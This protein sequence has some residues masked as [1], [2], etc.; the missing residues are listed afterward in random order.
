MQWLKS[1]YGDVEI[2][3]LSLRK[4]IL[5]DEFNGISDYFIELE[6][7]NDSIFKRF[8][9]KLKKTTTKAEYKKKLLSK[10]KKENYDY[11]YANSIMSLDWG[12]LIKN[13][14][15]N[16]KL[17]LH[18]HELQ[19]SVNYY[20][21]NFINDKDK[22]DKFICVSNL[23]QKNI[24]INYKVPIHKT[25][26]VYAFS[27]LKKEKLSSYDSV[28]KT[29]FVI[30]ASGTVNFRK[31]YDLFLCVAKALVSEIGDNIEFC[32]IGKF[33]NN[34]IKQEVF[35]DIKKAG[36]SKHVFFKGEFENPKDEF[37]KFDIF[38][39]LSREDP[40]P[41]VCIEVAN[42]GKP[43]ICFKGA[44]G[45]EEVLKYGG[46]K[47]VPY[48]DINAVAKE[49]KSYI[50]NPKEIFNDGKLAHQNFKDFTID[51]QSALIYKVLK[52]VK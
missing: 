33:S 36:L 11:I 42:L 20:A 30:G 7:K 16:S 49:V 32:W 37:K 13:K 22:V 27:N 15:P 47:I 17:I 26:V 23:V 2:H 24:I 41:L 38:L 25:D 50:S 4:G 31:G 21:P 51:N 10:L 43:I 48:L 52:S 46:G 45:T 18:L 19:L 29:K 9:N 34:K 40:F 12:V 28:S 1:N 44:T 39:M 6:N 8:I 3:S 35:A 5:S 14:I